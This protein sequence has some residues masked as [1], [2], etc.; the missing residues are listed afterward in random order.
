[1]KWKSTLFAA[2]AFLMLTGGLTASARGELP[3]DR[4]L[5]ILSFNI[6]NTMGM[7]GQRDLARTASVI[8]RQ[9]PDVVAVQEVDSVTGRSDGR[10]VLGDLAAEVLMY[11]TYAAAIDY[12][13]GKY[14]IGI[15]S[16]E[17]PLRHSIEHGHDM[18]PDALFL[19]F[20]H[21][22]LPMQMR[23]NP[24]SGDD[25]A[26]FSMQR[27]L[28]SAAIIREKGEDGQCGFDLHAF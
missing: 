18:L 14:G 4:R 24:D 25:A 11:P 1:M 17:K 13:G 26:P 16:R 27:R 15:L 20:R 8:R 28:P 7:D 19:S 23:W 9:R 2:T 21:F 22:P 10:Y 6:R 12:D 5:R 3:E